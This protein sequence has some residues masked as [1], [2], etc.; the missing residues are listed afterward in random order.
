MLKV[1]VNHTF[2]VRFLFM[3]A[4]FLVVKIERI[5]FQRVVSVVCRCLNV[6]ASVEIMFLHVVDPL[7][8]ITAQECRIENIEIRFHVFRIYIETIIDTINVKVSD[9]KIRTRE[10][11]IEINE[12][13][14]A[15]RNETPEKASGR[16]LLR[17]R[18]QVLQA[19]HREQAS[20]SRIRRVLADF[21]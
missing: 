8:A 18:S 16:F 2:S 10:Q 9:F 14:E 4:V 13:I 1:C 11:A 15:R 3:Q 6:D 17:V 12:Q 21:L 20:A 7:S 19:L 5:V